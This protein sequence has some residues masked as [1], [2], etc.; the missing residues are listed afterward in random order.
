MW[1]VD[2]TKEKFKST[3]SSGQNSQQKS[4][5]FPAE[6]ICL[7]GSLTIQKQDLPIVYHSGHEPVTR[8]DL[9]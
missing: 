4:Y 9:Y 6:T 3:A 7:F 5:T 1:L 8:G 2:A